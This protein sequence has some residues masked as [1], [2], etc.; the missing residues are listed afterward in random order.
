LFSELANDPAG[1]SLAKLSGRLEVSKT[2]LLYPLRLLVASGYVLHDRALYRLGPS[3]FRLAGAVM[4]SRALANAFRP[5]IEELT[6]RSG[7]STY[8]IVLD[9]EHGALVYI[10]ASYSPQSLRHSLPIGATCPLDCSA[11]GRLLLAY[12]DQHWKED[13]LCS[14]RPGLTTRSPLVDSVALRKELAAIREAG[15]SLSVDEPTAGSTEL[16]APIFGPAGT[17][18]AAITIAGPSTRLASRLSE[19]RHM[20][21]DVAARASTCGS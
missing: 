1:L 18:M 7:E 16:S 11:T 15:F 2:T 21:E 10:D 8:I 13:Y 14:T 9:C 20:V 6:S 5:H 17:V 12:A 4:A 3:M 19:L